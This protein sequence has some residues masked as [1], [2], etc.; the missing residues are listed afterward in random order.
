MQQQEQKQ[1][2]QQLKFIIFN[3]IWSFKTKTDSMYRNVEM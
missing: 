1:V 3:I 2:E